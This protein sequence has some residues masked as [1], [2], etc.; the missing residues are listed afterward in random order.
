ME[1]INLKGLSCPSPVIETKKVVATTGATELRIELDK[2]APYENV[3][4]F[5]ESCGYCVSTEQEGKDWLTLRATKAEDAGFQIDHGLK[6]IVVLIDGETVGRGDDTLGAVLMKSLLH[7]LKELKPLPWRL[8][9]I[10]AG[11]KL[12]EEGSDH[13]LFPCRVL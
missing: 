9:F 11:V 10:N 6:K 12:A 7:T 5:L 13:L 2:G 4:R 1:Y 3:S 8:I